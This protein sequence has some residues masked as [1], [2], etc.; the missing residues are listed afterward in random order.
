MR[1]PQPFAAKAAIAFSVSWAQVMLQALG[2]DLGGF[3]GDAE[4]E[5]EADHHRMT[6][7]ARVAA[8]ALPSSVRKIER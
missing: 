4:I 8:I 6:V 5:Q 3:A 7:R 1:C 2:V